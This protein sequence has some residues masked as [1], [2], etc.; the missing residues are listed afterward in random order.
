MSTSS[1]LKAY[2][3]V[4]QVIDFALNLLRD[5]CAEKRKNILIRGTVPAQLLVDKWKEMK[6]NKNEEE[7]QPEEVENH[8]EDEEKEEEKQLKE[9][10]KKCVKW[11]AEF[12]KVVAR[13]TG[14]GVYTPEQFDEYCMFRPNSDKIVAF[15]CPKNTNEGYSWD[16]FDGIAYVWKKEK[17]HWVVKFITVKSVCFD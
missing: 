16:D 7:K 5:E 8:T 3:Q 4:S 14:M 2:I 11:D 1:E 12:V 15:G 17:V 9:V 13:E 10:T 6:T